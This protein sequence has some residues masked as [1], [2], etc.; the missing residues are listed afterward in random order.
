PGGSRGLW[1][2]ESGCVS[3]QTTE[4]PLEGTLGRAFERSPRGGGEGA[5]KPVLDRSDRSIDGGSLVLK[6]RT[7]R[8]VASQVVPRRRTMPRTSSEPIPIARCKGV[9]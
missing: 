5:S 8:C 3:F 7:A 9:E 1:G 4:P 2:E 6:M